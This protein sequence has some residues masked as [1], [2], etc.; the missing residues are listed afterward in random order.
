MLYKQIIQ[1]LKYHR[2]RLGIGTQVLAQKIGVADS[3]VTKWES[4]SKIPNGT[5]LVNRINALGFNIN[6]YQY[7]KAI[8][9][10]Y[11]PNP[12]DVEWINN[13]YGKEVDI[14]YE[15]AQFIDY[16]TANGGIKEDWDACFRNWI[17]RS[18]KFRNIRRETKKGNSIYDPASIQER[19]KRILDVAGIRD[20]V[21]DGKRGFI[22][23][24]KK[25]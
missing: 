23:Y 4:Y 16:Y 25:D 24:R 9:R 11:I 7:K 18:I 21:Q 17:R 22:P 6:L 13:T 12:K 5:N 1:E 14:E 19:R 2:Q 10:K 20:T 3:L 15:T 8:D